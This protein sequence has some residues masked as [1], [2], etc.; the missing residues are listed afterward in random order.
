MAALVQEGDHLVLDVNGEKLS[1]L[2][3]LKGSG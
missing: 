3:K 1:L 2:Q